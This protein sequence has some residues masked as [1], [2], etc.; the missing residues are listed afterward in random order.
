MAKGIPPYCGCG[1]WHVAAEGDTCMAMSME[2][3]IKADHL[4]CVSPSL[5]I[6]FSFCDEQVIVGTVVCCMA[7]YW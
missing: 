1:A 5:G 2:Q 4:V 3:A 7:P 6:G